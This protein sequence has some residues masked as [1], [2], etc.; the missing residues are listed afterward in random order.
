[1]TESQPPSLIHARGLVKKFGDFVAVDGIDFDVAQGEA[2]GFLGPNRAGQ[3][4]TTNIL[5]TLVEA[6]DGKAEVVGYDVATEREAVRRN[7]GLAFPEPTLDVYL[8]AEQNLKFHGEL[9]GVDRATAAAR[10]KEVLEMVGLWERKDDLVR[11]FSGGMPASA[12]LV[13]ST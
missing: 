2:F 13:A 11:T 4:T 1:M 7:I 6:T 10:R 3:S 5:C 9:Y 8:S 12:A